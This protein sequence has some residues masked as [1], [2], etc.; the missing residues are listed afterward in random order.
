MND[1]TRGTFVARIAQNVHRVSNKTIQNEMLVEPK[2]NEDSNGLT[3][4]R[5]LSSL[6]A[7][8][9]GTTKVTSATSAPMPLLARAFSL[10]HD[11]HREAGR[12]SATGLA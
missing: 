2:W 12:R 4:Q 9:H 1:P 3:S 8:G 10:T 7:R 5:K 6:A 11:E